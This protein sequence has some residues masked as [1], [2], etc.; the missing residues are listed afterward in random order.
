MNADRRIVAIVLMLVTLAGFV[1][2]F[3]GIK[4]DYT[5]F[6]GLFAIAMVIVLGYMFVNIVREYREISREKKR[7]D[8]TAQSSY[9][10]RE[11]TDSSR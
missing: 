10:R 4:L 7:R 1:A 3:M 5:F 9:N 8:D 2:K 6:L 11:R